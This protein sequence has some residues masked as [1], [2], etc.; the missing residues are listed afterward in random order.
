MG[1]C[2]G[3]RATRSKFTYP[4]KEHE[5]KA[6]TRTIY[7]SANRSEC[8]SQVKFHDEMVESFVTGIACVRG[9]GPSPPIV[10]ANLEI[11]S[12]VITGRAA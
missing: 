10:R 7:S 3:L 5:C 6:S 2:L 1:I 12:P 9:V 8:G 11:A 4:T